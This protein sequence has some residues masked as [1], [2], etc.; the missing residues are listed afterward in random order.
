VLVLGI[1]PNRNNPYEEK[2]I[3]AYWTKWFTEM[4]IKHFEI[5]NADLPSNTDK[6]I[7]DFI[8]EKNP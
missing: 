6:I 5:K 8:L 4:K 1:N 2:V 7:K 3:K